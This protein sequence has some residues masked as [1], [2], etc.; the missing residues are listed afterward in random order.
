MR[1]YG[2]V[3]IALAVFVAAG[4]SSEGSGQR[5]AG[6][7]TTAPT[8]QSTSPDREARGRA[9]TEIIRATFSEVLD[10]S[11]VTPDTFRVQGNAVS[12]SGTVACSGMTAS[13]T[14]DAPLDTLTTY[15]VT[16]TT[17]VRDPAGNALKQDYTWAFSTKVPPWTGNEVT[18]T[19]YG[20]VQGY[21]DKEDTWVWRAIPFARPPVGPLRWKAPRDPESWSGTRRRK[22]FSDPCVQ[23]FVIGDSMLGNEDCLYLNVWRPRTTETDLP[24]Y[25]WIHGG[26]NSVGSAVIAE[27][28]SGVNVAS[29][30]N[31]VFVSLNYRLGP[32]GWFTHPALRSGQAGDEEDDSGNYAVLDHIKALTWIRENIEAFGGAPGKVMITGESAGARDV[33]TLLIAPRAQGLFHRAMSQSGGV[34][35]NSM[36]DGDA[37]GREVIIELLVRDGTASS[38]EEAETYL[39]GMSEAEIEAYLRGKQARA[40]LKCYT[41]NFAGMITF[42]SMFRD[43]TVLPEAGFDLFE[44]GD[45]ASKVPVILGTNKEERKIFIFLDPFFTGRDALYQIVATYSSDEWKT[46][47]VDQVARNLS[48]HA[49]Q[50]GVYA[51]QFLWGAWSETEGSVIP[52]PWGLKLGSCHTLEIPFFLG[53]DTVNV[54]MQLLMFTEENRMGREALSAAMMDYAARFART[55]DPNRPGSG[56]PEWEPW[57][58]V[59]GEPKS[60]L[61]DA[62][63]QNGLDIRMSTSELTREGIRE[64]MAAEVPEPLY[65][66]A[67]EYLG[68]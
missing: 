20:K 56:L 33:L 6:P 25:V 42:P 39:E 31:M 49:D 21:P 22:N 60:I 52:D 23:Y 38:P 9:L 3:F 47:G 48:S 8:V 51:Y 2:S 35:S 4:C 7:D 17:G 27:D 30:S 34:R 67:K 1:A 37:R 58:N 45:Y 14:P 40:I 10:A 63:S 62:D 24:V 16:I 13:F 43:G 32:M 55:G 54:L 64:R 46:G 11:T 28:Y 26:G 19:Y 53:R 15:T 59:P 29:R 65:S 50:P 68:W 36:E 5:S 66:E 57:S 41:P 18:Q 12:I 61:L 44:T